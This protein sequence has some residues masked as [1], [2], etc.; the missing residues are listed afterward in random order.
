MKT[1]SLRKEDSQHDWYIVDASNK[2]LGRLAT[3]LADKLRGKD[4]STFTPHIDGGDYVVVINAE[5]VKVTGN[6]FNNKK[7]YTHSTYPGGLKMKI[8]K[9]LIKTKPEYI[10]EKAVKG[11]LPKNKLGKQIF[12]KLKVYKGSE[13]PHESQQPQIW[14]PKI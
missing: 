7:Y 2:V 14:K 8:F 12:K 9:D 1:Q 11:M 3:K 13:H 4:K 10:I 5:K 6:K